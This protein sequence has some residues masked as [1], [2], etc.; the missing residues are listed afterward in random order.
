MKKL[1]TCGLLVTAAVSFTQAQIPNPRIP[2]TPHNPN[3]KPIPE[4]K[5]I[6]KAPDLAVGLL[7]IISA[8]YN[9]DTRRTSIKVSVKITNTGTATSPA[10]IVAF[11]VYTHDMEG[12]LDPDRKFWQ[13]FGEPFSI[14]AL[15]PGSTITRFA[16]YHGLHLVKDV[17][18][19]SHLQINPYGAFEELSNAN[20]QTDEFN[21]TVN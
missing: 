10:S 9:P 13:K 8:T 4:V 12:R 16:T 2:S 19:R 21:L 5:I 15:A 3:Q 18:Y 14:P 17:T 20:N 6:K 11:E 7:D 1:F